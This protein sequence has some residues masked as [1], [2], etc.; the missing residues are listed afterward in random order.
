MLEMLRK[1]ANRLRQD[2]VRLFLLKLRYHAKLRLWQMIGRP[3]AGFYNEANRPKFGA[4]ERGQIQSDIQGF[5]RKPLFSVILPVYNVSPKWLAKAVASV[6]TQLYPYWEL[7]LA[8]DA[9]PNAETRRAAAALAAADQRIK[10][11]MLEKNHGIAGCSNAAARLAGGEY[12][13]FLDHDDELAPDALYETAKAICKSGAEVLYSDE[14]LISSAGKVLSAHFKP[15]FSPDLLFSHNYITHLLVIKKTLFDRI[16]GFDGTCDGAQDYDLILKAAERANRVYHIPRVL[17]RW[18]S[19]A[20]STSA[21]PGAKTYAHEAGRR[22]L[23]AALER[24]KI[25]AEVLDGY[26]PFFYRVKRRIAAKPHV[27]III[28]FRDQPDMLEKCVRSVLERSTYAHFDILGISNGSRRVETF[29]LMQRLARGDARVRFMEFDEPFNYSRINNAAVKQVAGTH[30]VLMNNDIEVITADW[31]EALLEH[32]QRP[33]VGAVGA[34]LIY[35]SDKIQHAG[36]VVGIAGFAGH[37]HRHVHRNLPGYMSRLKV[38]QNVSAVTGALLM[39]KKELYLEA[40]GL[41][42]KNLTI[43]LNDVDFCLRLRSRGLWNIFT[44]FCEA[45]HYESASRGYETTPAKRERFQR[46]IAYFQAKWRQ[47]LEAGDPFYNPNLSLK[48]EDFAYR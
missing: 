44:P 39:V 37:A 23:V 28:P 9:S 15:D 43:A 11:V 21:D 7:C 40:G 42:E 36:V 10:V 34:K 17:Y 31:I 25:D 29:R 45:Y 32:S 18:R 41:D 2:G 6:Q 3:V 35:G 24:K 12:L 46:E 16:G 4:R 30:V 22:A 5:S 19:I 8:D 47:L 14:E 13:T 26:Q 20:G 33:E 1:A 48:R 27:S 38:I